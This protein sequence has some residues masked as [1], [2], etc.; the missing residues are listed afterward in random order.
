MRYSRY[1]FWQ[2]GGVDGGFGMHLC[3]EPLQRPRG[4][5]GLLAMRIDRRYEPSGLNERIYLCLRQW[6]HFRFGFDPTLYLACEL[7]ENGC[8]WG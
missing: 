1:D 7:G 4:E 6:L 3:R 5:P 8:E 2:P